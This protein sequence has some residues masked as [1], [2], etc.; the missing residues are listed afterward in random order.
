MYTGLDASSSNNRRRVFIT[1][2]SRPSL[3]ALSR[4]QILVSNDSWVAT[5]PPFIDSSASVRYSVA[6]SS[7]G[8]PSRVTRRSA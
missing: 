2:R 5:R 7:N 1:V 3:P 4:F 8:L 6:V